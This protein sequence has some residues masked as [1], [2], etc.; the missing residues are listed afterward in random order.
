MATTPLEL[1]QSLEAFPADLLEQAK[2][3]LCALI[4][5]RI[6]VGA[7]QIWCGEPL[8]NALVNANSP[9][10]TFEDKVHKYARIEISFHDS[11]VKLLYKLK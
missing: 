11:A 8:V 2:T 7:L 6:R 5:D 4:G 9:T 10:P 1:V 3:Q